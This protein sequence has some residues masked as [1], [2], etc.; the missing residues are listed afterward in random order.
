MLDV[1]VR[2]DILN[3]LKDL[4]QERGIACI[5]IT[6]DLGSARYLADRIMVMYA[7]Y[8][9]EGAAGDLL[10][11]DPLHPYTRLLLSAVPDP[12]RSITSDLEGGSGAPQLVDPPPGCPFAGRCP[13]VMERC[14]RELPEMREIDGRFIR[15]FLHVNS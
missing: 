6:H 4:K 1:S 5:Y 14:R 9:V 7:G 15:C 11:D 12:H 13:K 2:M 10:M 8:I 3:L